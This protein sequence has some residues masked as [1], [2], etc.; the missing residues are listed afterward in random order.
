M[1]KSLETVERLYE[2]VC[3]G[4]S[5]QASAEATGVSRTR[6]AFFW[7]RSAPM[8]LEISMGRTGGLEGS[9]PPRDAPGEGPCGEPGTTRRPLASEDRAVIA[10][11]VR[12]CLSYQQ[13]GDL[14]GRTKS[15]LW[16]EVARNSGPDGS[17]WAPVAHRLAHEHRRRPKAFK[18]VE[19]P[20]LCS[21]SRSG[22][23]RAGPRS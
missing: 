12:Q 6:A 21:R 9:S 22:W 20:A 19:Q 3:R 18:L 17:Y 16:R 2:L 13:I 15:V 4:N 8:R 10:A 11:G 7:R 1:T 14:V 5:I 23:T